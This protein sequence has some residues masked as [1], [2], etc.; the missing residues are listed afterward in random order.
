MV[1][2]YE[3]RASRPGHLS[4]DRRSDSACDPRSP[5]GRA[6]AGQRSGRRLRADQ[7]GDLEAPASAARESAGHR[8]EGRSRAVVHAQPGATREG[9]GVARGLSRVLAAESGRPKALPGG[10]M[11]AH[12]IADVTEG[13]VLARVEIAVP[14]ERVFRAITTEELAKWWGSAELYRTTKHTVDLR[15][16][17][18]YRSDGIGRDGTPFRRIDLEDLAA[19]VKRRA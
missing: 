14:P 2:R 1:T 5:A 10:Y 8:R 19:D 18:E 3:D 9:G 15:P 16:G 7:T 13:I 11:K 6:G 4:S 12:A 17:G